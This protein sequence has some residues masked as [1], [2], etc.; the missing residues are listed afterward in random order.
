M[1]T[2]FSTPVTPTRESPT[3]TPGVRSWTSS[4]APL[5]GESEGLSRVAA[6]APSL[7]RETR[8]ARHRPRDRRFWYHSAL[9]LASV[10]RGSRGKRFA[11][12]RRIATA[13]ERTQRTGGLA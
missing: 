2:T 7:A 4:P 6:T 3:G 10:L 8:L 5:V 11:D 9:S 1:R 12:T 13:D